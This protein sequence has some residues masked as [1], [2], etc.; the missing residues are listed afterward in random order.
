MK[1][2]LNKQILRY[3][4]KQPHDRWPLMR[5]SFERSSP[6]LYF[7][8]MKNI[9]YGDFFCKL[10]NVS[11]TRKSKRLKRKLFDLFGLTAKHKILG[12]CLFINVSSTSNV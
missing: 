3:E 8:F 11:E 1:I 12:N 6:I 4:L 7:S 10:A 2:N 5:R 9:S